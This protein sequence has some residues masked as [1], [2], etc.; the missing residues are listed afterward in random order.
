IDSAAKSQSDRFSV[1]LGLPQSQKLFGNL[2]YSYVKTKNNNATGS[3][4]SFDPYD[5]SQEFS[6]GTADGVHSVG[7]YFYFNLPSKISVGTDFSV[8]SGS[9]FNITTGRDTNGDGYY[10]ERPSFATDLSKAGVI[11]TQYGVLDPNPAPGD[12]L[13]PRNLGRGS[14]TIF[15]N[16]SISK[17]F[18]FQ[19]D[20]VKKTP[21]KRSLNFSLRVSNLFNIINKSTPIGNMASPNFLRSLSSYSDG[22]ITIINGAQQ[23]NFAGRSM[24]LSVGFSF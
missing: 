13:I 9:R 11:S 16:S 4:S 24:N 22:G 19:E 23:E 10:S 1:N 15:F 2:R 17:S 5:F 14:R 6:P 7:G 12:K 20:K 18:G 8:N 3:G 21:P